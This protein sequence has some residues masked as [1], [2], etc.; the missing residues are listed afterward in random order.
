MKLGVLKPEDAANRAKEKVREWD[1]GRAKDRLRGNAGGGK[2]APEPVAVVATRPVAGE[3]AE[4]VQQPP[5]S[6]RLPPLAPPGISAPPRNP[7]HCMIGV[8][9]MTPEAQKKEFGKRLLEAVES[10]RESAGDINW[11]VSQG[12]DLEA[13]NMDGMTPLIVA[14]FNGYGSTILMLLLSG[15]NRSARDNEGRT[16]LYAAASEGRTEIVKLLLRTD[17]GKAMMDPDTRD[18]HGKTPLMRAAWRGHM[19]T[20]QV[21]LD[22]GADVN[23]KD[24]N[25]RTALD[26]V[27]AAGQMHIVSYLRSRGAVG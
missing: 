2:P 16:A 4:A 18:N 22:A 10:G 23:A 6:F 25:G 27:M 1:A 12:A 13:R 19:E 7:R 20:V 5:L 26:K 14:S 11:L 9:L 17:P 8:P 24:E 15:A 3:P 21:L